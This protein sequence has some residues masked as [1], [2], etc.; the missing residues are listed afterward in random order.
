MKY[1]RNCG[2]EVEDDDSYCG[3]CGNKLNE[4]Y[5]QDKS[6]RQDFKDESFSDEDFS[7]DFDNEFEKIDD[8]DNDNEFERADDF[9]D[10]DFTESQFQADSSSSTN[11]GYCERKP[12]LINKEANEAN[13][14]GIL[15]L[16]L[17]MLG[18][19]LGI[20][21]GILGLIKAKKAMEL[22][23]TGE[24]DGKSKANNAKTL[25]IIGIVFGSLWLLFYNFS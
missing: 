11:G 6:S 4:N 13:T 10:S 5:S 1:C 21:F 15:A 18:G 22:C 8:F 14:F 17:G 20:V 25:S 7:S 9:D 24:Y 12:L 2:A 23:K 16:I 19:V 3:Y